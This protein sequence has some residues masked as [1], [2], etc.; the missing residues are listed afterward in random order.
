MHITVIVLKI[1]IAKFFL[2]FFP[3]TF[4]QHILAFLFYIRQFN[5]RNTFIFCLFTNLKCSSFQLIIGNNE[6]SI[7]YN[8]V[9]AMHNTPTFV[10]CKTRFIMA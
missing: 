9:I 2:Y 8:P 7:F 1:V 10:F 5:Y 3:I 6:I 4:P